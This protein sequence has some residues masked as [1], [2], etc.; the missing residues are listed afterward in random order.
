MKYDKNVIGAGSVGAIVAMICV[1]LIIGAVLMYNI[2][3][4]SG[5]NNHYSRLLEEGR[6]ALIE[7]D[8]DSIPGYDID[9]PNY[10]YWLRIDPP[11]AFLR[12]SSTEHAVLAASLDQSLYNQTDGKYRYL[13]SEQGG[14]CIYLPNEM[15]LVR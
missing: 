8:G 12:G 9:C 10:Q 13:A 5:A 3:Y 2:A 14:I 7:Q 1:V 15:P 11:P 6:I 4:T